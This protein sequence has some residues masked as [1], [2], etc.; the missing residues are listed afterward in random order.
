MAGILYNRGERV[1]LDA[2]LGGEAVPFGS[3]QLIPTAGASWGLGLGTRVGGVG[4]ATH[5]AD[6]ITTIA[7][8][9]TTLANGYARAPILRDQSVS[10][11][12]ASTLVGSSYE[13]TAAQVSFGLFTGAPNPN[14]ATLW[15]LAGDTT[16][17]HDN[18]LFGADLS[19]T[20]T[21]GNGD[22]E[23]V[24]PSFQQT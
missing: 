22:S 16:I 1:F 2:V 11:W 10:G 7:E 20:R 18:A 14:G 5:K 3:P 24:V 19:A 4:D 12:P 6:T 21:F 9:G 17:N 8:L 23:R 15:F 13:T